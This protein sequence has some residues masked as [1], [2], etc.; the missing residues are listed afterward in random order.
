MEVPASSADQRIVLARHGETEWSRDGRHTGRTD[1]P[2]TNLGVRQGAA[3]GPC[4]EGW[5]FARVLTSP[6]GRA[7]ETCRLAGL[8][9]RAEVVEDL[10]E[11]DYGDY[12]GRTTADIRAQRPGWF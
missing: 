4:L 1:L 6:L 8:G 11:W 9:D 5:S 10:R 7:R 3:L 12:E 2:L